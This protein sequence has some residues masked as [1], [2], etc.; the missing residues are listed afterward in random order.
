MSEINFYYLEEPTLSNLN[1][2]FVSA[3]TNNP[4]TCDDSEANKWIYDDECENDMK[5]ELR[6]NVMFIM[7]ENDID[8]EG[9]DN[10]VLKLD[11]ETV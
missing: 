3:D 1:R 6:D 4:P 10:E 2:I 7:E 8:L 11:L 5:D 9:L